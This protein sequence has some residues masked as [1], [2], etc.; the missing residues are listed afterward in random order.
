MIDTA[1]DAGA[2]MIDVPTDANEA[3]VTY[4]LGKNFRRVISGFVTTAGTATSM[5]TFSELSAIDSRLHGFA[6]DAVGYLGRA[7][8]EAQA[9][10]E[11]IFGS[12]RTG[13]RG[14]GWKVV[15]SGAITDWLSPGSLY[16]FKSSTMSYVFGDLSGTRASTGTIT[17]KFKYDTLPTTTTQYGAIKVFST[18]EDPANPSADSVVGYKLGLQANGNL[19]LN[20]TDGAS[21][22]V[23]TANGG[24]ALVAGTEYTVTLEWDDTGGSNKVRITRVDTGTTS[25]WITEGATFYRGNYIG[26]FSTLS[27]G[28]L[29]LTDLSVE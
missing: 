9:S 28:V 26:A 8:G 5:D 29:R 1:A 12:I 16:L 13:R 10:A 27:D 4:A 2:W 15:N 25:G 3:L 23:A 18:S 6:S 20:R 24:G 7:G 11:S 17:A 21:T 22:G 19:F 14:A